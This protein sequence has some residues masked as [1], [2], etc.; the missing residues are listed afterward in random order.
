MAGDYPPQAW[1]VKVTQ[2]FEVYLYFAEGINAE[3]DSELYDIVAEEAINAAFGEDGLTA[4]IDE[5][6]EHLNG[7]L[8]YVDTFDPDV[9]VQYN[10]QGMPTII[11]AALEQKGLLKNVQEN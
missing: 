11:A 7:Y 1:K 6:T 8:A 4:V 10:I 5:E 2:T 3:D 9:D